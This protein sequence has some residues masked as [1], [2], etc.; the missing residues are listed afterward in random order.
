MTTSPD[1]LFI[2]ISFVIF[3]MS[4]ILHEIAHGYVA[5]KLG[6]YTAKLDGRLT[7]NPV[8][9]IDPLGTIAI[10]L[11]L[12]FLGS[13]VV[14]GWAKP[15][16]VNW[17]N[18]RGGEKS[19]FWVSIAGIVVNV[20]L[21]LLA[22]LG[23]RVLALSG[24]DLASSWAAALLYILVTY[25]VLLALF[26]LVP[27]PPLDG[28]RLLRTTLP[29]EYQTVLDQ[30]EPFGFVLLFLF[31]LVFGNSLSQSVQQIVHALTGF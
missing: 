20:T 8:P 23:L 15:V 24:I 10:P 13:P 12:F 22:S 30:L 17:Y 3:I 21:A 31:L 5:M 27:I 29:R 26:N 7:L 2:I 9:H 11:A 1:L 14:F 4:V 25:N 19:Y 28:S 16:P 6:D 18:L